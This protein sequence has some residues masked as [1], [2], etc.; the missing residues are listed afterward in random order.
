MFEL[1]HCFY[2]FVL[3]GDPGKPGDPGR[4]VRFLFPVCFENWSCFVVVITFIYI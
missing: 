2:F 4:D 1:M 3:Q